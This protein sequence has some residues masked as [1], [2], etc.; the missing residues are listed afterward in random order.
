MDTI[1]LNGSINPLNIFKILNYKRKFRK[2]HPLYF[3]QDGLLV[4]CGPQGSGKTLSA[5]QYIRELCDF[6]PK[7]LLVTNTEIKGLNPYT[8]VIEYEGIESITNIENGEEG[9]IYFID[10]IHLEFNSL[11]RAEMLP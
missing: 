7:A 10:E 8:R 5:V 6:Y 11:E 4:F 3:G 9:V 1:F 2:E